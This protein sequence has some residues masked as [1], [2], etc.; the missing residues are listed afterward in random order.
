MKVRLTSLERRALAELVR[1]VDPS[2]TVGVPASYI[3]A[4]LREP[5]TDVFLAL[6]R[7]AR[8]GHVADRP[9]ADV[10][11]FLPTAKGRKEVQS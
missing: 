9:G 2:D 10:T 3:A 4:L 5:T 1:R 7:L 6:R 11:A 8:Y